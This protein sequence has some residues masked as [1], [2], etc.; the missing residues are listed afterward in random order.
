MSWPSVQDE[1][2][3]GAYLRSN[4]TDEQFNKWEHFSLRGHSEKGE[5]DSTI[6]LS[7]AKSS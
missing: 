6:Q 5:Y 1:F 2:K 7:V 3:S 4:G